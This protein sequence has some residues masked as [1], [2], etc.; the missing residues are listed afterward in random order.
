[1]MNTIRLIAI[2]LPMTLLLACGGG[3]GGSAAAPTTPNTPTPQTLPDALIT[4]AEA[5]RNRITD[6][7]A[8]QQIQHLLLHKH[9]KRSNRE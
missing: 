1:M 6:P 2:A 7:T 4:D 9:N 5:A 3:G 8:P